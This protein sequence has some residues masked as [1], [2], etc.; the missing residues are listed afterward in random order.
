MK[1]RAGAYDKGSK[2]KGKYMVIE[3]RSAAEAILLVKRRFPGVPL[4]RFFAFPSEAG[5][6]SDNRL[7][8]F[9]NPR[10]PKGAQ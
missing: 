10:T 7:H 5:D 1:F 4:P 2:T 9:V 8:T 6:S 3:A